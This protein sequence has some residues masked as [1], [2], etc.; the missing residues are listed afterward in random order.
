MEIDLFII[1]LEIISKILFDKL[2]NR[3][4]L[5]FFLESLNSH[6]PWHFFPTKKGDIFRFSKE[7][8]NGKVYFYK[9]DLRASTDDIECL[10]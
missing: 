5:F 2:E 3:L 9:K 10:Q 7:S 4:E 8:S 1:T 6:P